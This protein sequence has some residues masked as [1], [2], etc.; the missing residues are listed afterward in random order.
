MKNI[1]VVGASGF[2]GGHLVRAL[3][4]EGRTVRCL[5]RNPEK[6]AALVGPRCEAVQGD[7]S[8]PSSLLQALEGVDAVYLTVHTLSPQ[9][10]SPGQG[11]MEI[12]FQ[13]LENIVAACHTRG[14]KRL[15]S[16][17]S[18]GIGPQATN[19]WTQGRWKGEQRL[20]ASGLDVT[21]VMPGQIV[22]R[23]GHGFDTMEAQARRRVAVVMGSGRRPWRNIAVED[24]VYYLVGVLD[25]ART[26]GHRY[27]V[28]CDDVLTYHQ[29]VDTA[30]EVLGRP[31]PFKIDIPG[32]FLVALAPLIEGRSG[33][34]PGALAGLFGGEA[35]D[36]VGDPDPIRA[37]L[38]RP[39][40]SY[41]RAVEAALKSEVQ[42][43]SS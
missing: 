7:I 39:P 40:L 43:A 35:T 17:T 10:A 19:P 21:V 14:V 13:G 9:P 11:F 34:P 2:V 20:M 29:M 25:D 16:L 28:G 1:L 33:L 3:V 15:I 37:L 30:A 26:Y 36:M 24:L 41:R 38:P 31:H 6:V 18:L 32:W 42:Q 5:T 27:E 23:G 12:E 4:E 22:G 8:D